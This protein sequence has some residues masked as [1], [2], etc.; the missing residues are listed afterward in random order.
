MS[1]VLVKDRHP[2]RDELAKRFSNCC[3]GMTTRVF[4]AKLAAY[5]RYIHAG[6]RLGLYAALSSQGTA[7]ATQLAAV[8]HRTA[9]V[10]L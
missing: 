10:C 6:G 9:P 1:S 8:V 4:E 2:S 3:G 5:D 7:T